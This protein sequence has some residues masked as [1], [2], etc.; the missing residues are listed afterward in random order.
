M[1]GVN[2]SGAF[3]RKDTAVQQLP[4]K[5]LA[6]GA[7]YF[8]ELSRRIESIVPTETTKNVPL[9][10]ISKPSGNGPGLE[11]DGER[12]ILTVCINGEQAK[13]E[14]IGRILPK[15]GQPE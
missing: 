13:I 5:P 9:I 11:I 7:N 1:K 3:I 10:T 14:L 6:L 15:F 4:E 12:L 2:L 8:R